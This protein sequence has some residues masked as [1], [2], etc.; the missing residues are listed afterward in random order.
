MWRGIGVTV[1]TMVCLGAVVGA[2]ISVIS[3]LARG[4]HAR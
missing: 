2:I 1:V 4:A 3:I